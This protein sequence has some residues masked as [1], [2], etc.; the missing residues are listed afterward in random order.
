MTVVAVVEAFHES[1]AESLGTESAAHWPG[2]SWPTGTVKRLPKR[3][4]VT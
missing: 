1:G 4:S 2:T 3:R